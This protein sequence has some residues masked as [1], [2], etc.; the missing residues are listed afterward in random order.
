VSTVRVHL[1]KPVSGRRGIRSNG[2]AVA[3]V[4]VV[5]VLLVARALVALVVRV[6]LHVGGLVVLALVAP[7][8]ARVS[9]ILGGVI[10]VV[11]RVIIA[12]SRSRE[13]VGERRRRP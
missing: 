10:V 6:H 1:I 11:A 13:C 4:A 2:V 3:I 9:H 7:R 5:A 12:Y 8:A